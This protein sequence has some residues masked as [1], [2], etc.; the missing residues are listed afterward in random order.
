MSVPSPEPPSTAPLCHWLG[1]AALA[2]A[3]AASVEVVL[4]S[5][6]VPLALS[7]PAG[8][9]LFWVGSV[10][11]LAPVCVATALVLR[12]LAARQRPRSG[13]SSSLLVAAIAI[14]VLVTA[15]TRLLRAYIA[16]QD[17]QFPHPVGLL[18]TALVF[19]F[20]VA[21]LLGYHALQR[22]LHPRFRPSLRF[23]RRLLVQRVRS[24]I[25]VASD[26][27]IAGEGVSG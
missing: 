7:D 13:N 21:G 20:V 14:A 18:E 12:W 11:Y 24:S 17:V 16:H 5:I 3:Y 9:A 26:A 6:A 2:A 25:R 15:A 10:A 8:F 1:H 4:T 19:G 27:P 22:W 23:E